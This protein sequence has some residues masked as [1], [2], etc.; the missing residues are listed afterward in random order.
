MEDLAK[1]IK[2]IWFWPFKRIKNAIFQQKYYSHIKSSFNLSRVLLNEKDLKTL[3]LAFKR[4]VDVCAIADDFR[5]GFGRH[6]KP[7]SRK[8]RNEQNF[9]VPPDIDESTKVNLDIEAIKAIM[10]ED[11]PESSFHSEEF[12][13]SDLVKNEGIS[14]EF[15][16]LFQKVSS[17]PIKIRYLKHYA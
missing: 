12:T 7:D 15:Q 11:T 17:T 13:Y 4:V 5:Q 16:Q 1:K 10:I 6:R 9:E 8:D 14:H 3:Y 2:R